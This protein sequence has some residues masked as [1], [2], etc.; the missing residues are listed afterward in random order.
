MRVSPL[1]S[2]F[3]NNRCSQVLLL[4][5]KSQQIMRQKF[6]DA[7]QESWRLLFSPLWATARKRNRHKKGKNSIH[8][9]ST[10]LDIL[11]TS[12]S[13]L[14]V[15]PKNIPKHYPL[16]KKLTMFRQQSSFGVFWDIFLIFLSL[17]SCGLYVASTY[18]FGYRS[19]QY[20]FQLDFVTTGFFMV[21]YLLNF[22]SAS[23]KIV[24][25]FSPS[26][27]VDILT[28]LPIWLSMSVRNFRTLAILRFVRILRLVRILRAFKVLRSLN[29]VRRQVITLIL[30]LI[31]LVF[32]AAGVID[33]MENDIRVQLAKQPCLF[34]NAHTNWEPS[35]SKFEP[36]P[37]VSGCDCVPFNCRA[38]YANGD[39][40]GQPSDVRCTRWTFLDCFYF[41]V[42]TGGLDTDE[43]IYFIFILFTSHSIFSLQW[44]L[45]D[46][47]I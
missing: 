32:M 37:E 16:H 20:F 23:P 38:V 40:M 15:F 2:V 45:L 3:N 34:I 47:A 24:H 11:R 14:R 6:V 1:I 5:V 29:G 17:L 9:I 35:C 46:M 8:D 13:Q 18:S 41:M 10:C 36:A 12:S 44:R 25:F 28:I 42:V 43:V 22:L 7:C 31:T 39:K 26:S 30:T 27:F 21:D 33:I 19:A 4:A